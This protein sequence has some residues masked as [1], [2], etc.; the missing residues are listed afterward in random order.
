MA[1]TGFIG[2]TSGEDSDDNKIALLFQ[3][4]IIFLV[5]DVLSCKEIKINI[6]THT[7]KI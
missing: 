5:Y 3:H 6:N 7:G 4:T 1:N 2:S